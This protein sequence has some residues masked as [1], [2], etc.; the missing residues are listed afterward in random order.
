MDMDIKQDNL[1]VK[2]YY[3]SKSLL[4]LQENS[5]PKLMC[6]TT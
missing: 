2:L 1:L 3:T 4:S 6:K 5:N